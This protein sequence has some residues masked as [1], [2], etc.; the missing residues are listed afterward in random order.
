MIIGGYR[1]MVYDFI[2]I[3]TSNFDTI[4][5]TATK[6]S[7]GI[8]IEPVKPYLDELPNLPNVT[9]LNKAVG[10]VDSSLYIYYI[11][12]VEITKLFPP[13]YKYLH[14]CNMLDSPHPAQVAALKKFNLDPKVYIKRKQ[15]P[16]IS[17]T[18]LVEQY[19]IEG[20][21]LLKIDAEGYDAKILD[22]YRQIYETNKSVIANEIIFE[23]NPLTN[24]KEMMETL[25][26]FKKTYIF[27]DKLWGNVHLIK[28]D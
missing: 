20:I 15:I 13:Q 18:T 23:V 9:K 1:L 8:C 6:L 11:E 25:E 14:G 12:P 3:G 7:T 26:P 19:N 24:I 16:V 2:E 21:K 27:P 4:I 22:G 10:D 17:F 28:A 5:E